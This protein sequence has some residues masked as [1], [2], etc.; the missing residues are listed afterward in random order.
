[1]FSGCSNLKYIDLSNFNCSSS[2]SI[3]SMFE[4]CLGLIYLNLKSFKVKTDVNKDNIFNRIYTKTKFCS[5][6]ATIINAIT[7]L[8]LSLDCNDDCFKENIK[9]DQTQAKVYVQSCRNYEY[10]KIC[11][12][13]CPKGTLVNGNIC[14]DNKCLKINHNSIVCFGNTPEG[15]YFDT[16]VELYKKC[17]QGCK[18][19]YGQGN[20]TNNNCIE[21]S[22]NLESSYDLKLSATIVHY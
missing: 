4:D 6:D 18:F 2:N 11:I 13:E 15:Y 8:S 17:Y 22:I 3:N 19:C 1:M 16:E 7:S 14:E 9:I 20:E 21:D 5:E 10:N 12:N